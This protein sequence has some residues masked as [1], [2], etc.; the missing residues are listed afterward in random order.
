MNEWIE[1]KIRT[2]RWDFTLF[3]EE[4][5]D[6]KANNIYLECEW[7]FYFVMSMKTSEHEAGGIY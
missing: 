7:N 4:Y 5:E 6:N 2:F 1:L 3:G